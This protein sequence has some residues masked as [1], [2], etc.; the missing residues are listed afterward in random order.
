MHYYTLMKKYYWTRERMI[1]ILKKLFESN[2]Y[3]TLF[4]PIVFSLIQ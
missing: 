1:E 4:I 3:C 2:K